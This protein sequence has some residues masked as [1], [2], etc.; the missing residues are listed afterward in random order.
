MTAGKPSLL[1]RKTRCPLETFTVVFLFKYAFITA[2]HGSPKTQNIQNAVTHAQ[3][4]KPLARGAA[5]QV[6]PVRKQR[7]ITHRLPIVRLL[8]RA[9]GFD[10]RSEVALKRLFAYRFNASTFQLFKAS[11][12]H[13]AFGG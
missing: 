10:A 3:S 11:H 9:T 8:P 4:G 6:P 7:P 13:F 2:C 1:A 5:E 12:F